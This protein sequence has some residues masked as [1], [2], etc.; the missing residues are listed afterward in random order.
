MFRFGFKKVSDRT[1]SEADNN[2]GTSAAAGVSDVSASAALDV[3]AE[4]QCNAVIVRDPAKPPAL[5]VDK[6]ITLGPIVMNRETK[7][8]GRGFRNDWTTARSW[9]EYSS[10]EDKV[11]CFPCRLFARY[12]STSQKKGHEAFISAGYND[13]KHALEK[14]RGF[15]QHETSELHQFCEESLTN[16]RKQLV[17]SESNPCIQASLSEAFR[18]RQRQQ[19]NE[20]QENRRYISKLSDAMRFL[21]RLGLAVR[22]HR[23]SDESLHRGN[24]LELLTLLRQSDEF[25]DAQL[26]SR[27]GNAHYLSPK[28]QNQLIDAIGYEVLDVI[29]DRVRKADFFSVTM[30]ETTDLAHLEQVAIVVRYCDE[31]FNAFERLISVVE[32]PTV[33]GERLAEVLLSSLKRHRFDTNKMCAQTYDGAAAM[34]GNKRGVQAVIKQTAPQAHYNH[35]RSHSCNL[36]I[37]KSVQCSRFGR[38]FFGVLEQ[39]FSVIEGSA[40]RHSWFMEYQSAAGLR[41]KPL[42]GLSETRWNCQGRSVQVIRSRLLAVTETLERIRNESADRKVIGEAVGLLAYAS[43]FEF[44]VAIEFFSKLLSPLDTLT[45]AVQGPDSTLHTVATLSRAACDCLHELRED[46]DSVVAD[47][48]KLAADNDIETELPDRRPRKVS[49]RMD[50]SAENESVLSAMDELKREM[51]EVVDMALS[52]LKAR[53]FGNG[54]QLYE[55]AAMLM[56]KTTTSEQLH[57]LIETLYPD[58]VDAD[59]AAAEFNV[60]R[61]LETWTNGTTLQQR[62]VAC[63]A[64]LTEIRKVYRI[65]ITVPV[66]SAECERTFSKLALIKNKLR[67]TCG[68]QRLENLLVCSVERDIVQQVDVERIVDRFAALTD[69]RRLVLTQK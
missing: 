29:G 60:V 43:K 66:T 18:E 10:S 24:F 36:V 50:S 61:R 59:V 49:R 44:A 32:S 16:R 26:A 9:L 62:A 37:V 27:P 25:L 23:E 38:N 15:S 31:N 35:C 19:Q 41:P 58:A 12:M 7:P 20:I 1:S 55:L 54:G 11:F 21:A 2:V 6:E 57:K 51:T 39:L 42:K 69:N 45:T 30:D 33:T 34:S 56:D 22:G 40:K 67:S 5:S 48:V 63:P 52:E 3:T 28:S 53:F 64:S 47:A 13:W 65:I 46:L 17:D 68:Q 14:D 8:C 4:T